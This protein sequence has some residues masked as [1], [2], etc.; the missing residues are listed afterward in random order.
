MSEIAGQIIS[1][2]ALRVESDLPARSA[3]AS[4][5][6]DFYP[7]SPCGERPKCFLTIFAVTLF[8]STLS[9]WRATAEYKTSQLADA[10]ISIHALRVESDRPCTD[11]TKDGGKISIHALRVESDAQEPAISS[12]ISRFL[13]TLSVWRATLLLDSRGQRFF[14]FYPRS[15]CGERRVSALSLSLALRFLST[16][17]VWRATYCRS[18]GRRGPRYFYPRSPCGERRWSFWRSF[19]PATYFYPRSPCGERLTIVFHSATTFTFLSTLSVWRATVS[20][21]LSDMRK[22]ISIHALR[23]ESDFCRLVSSCLICYFY[24]RSP[25]GE[26]PAPGAV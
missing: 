6:R 1:I 5:L 20:D 8:L 12:T 10:W 24:P 16:L 23:V 4:F 13:S 17:S 26:R 14:D 15:P 19:R 21:I 18:S 9:V 22:I 7:R 2:H 3:S 25:C 11:S